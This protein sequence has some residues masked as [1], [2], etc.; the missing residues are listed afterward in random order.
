MFALFWND[1]IRELAVCKHL[2]ANH[3]F[4]LCTVIFEN[5]NWCFLSLWDLILYIYGCDT[6]LLIGLWSMV[7]ECSLPAVS[8]HGVGRSSVHFCFSRALLHPLR[9]GSPHNLVTSQRPHLPTPSPITDE[10]GGHSCSTCSTASAF[11][12]PHTLMPPRPTVLTVDWAKHPLPPAPPS[13]PF[14]GFWC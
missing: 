10:L 3:L 9:G 13:L 12:A 7:T 14:W 4:C 5:L 6:P 11:H 8:S 2:F 1:K